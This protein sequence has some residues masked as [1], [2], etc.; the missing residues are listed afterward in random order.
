MLIKV[1]AGVLMLGWI[2]TL[3]VV[4]GARWISGAPLLAASPTPVKVTRL[5]T[6]ADVFANA[7]SC[8]S[9]VLCMRNEGLQPYLG[10]SGGRLGARNV[11]EYKP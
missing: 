8:R 11:F 6:G 1:I 4:T 7:V 10:S 2:P 5:Y 9:R 3:A